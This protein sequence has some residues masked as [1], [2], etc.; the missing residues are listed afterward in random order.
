MEKARKDHNSFPQGDV[1][2]NVTLQPLGNPHLKAR[3][4]IFES[5]LE[6]GICRSVP[7]NM[8]IRTANGRASL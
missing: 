7:F 5:L 2:R 1:A 8:R 3:Y 4:V 6:K